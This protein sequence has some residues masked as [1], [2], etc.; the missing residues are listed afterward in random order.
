VRGT[1]TFAAFAVLCALCVESAFA[2]KA[3]NP[4]HREITA[5]WVIDHFGEKVPDAS[6]LVPYSVHFH[7]ILRSCKISAENLTNTMLFLAYKASDQ[8]QRFVTSLMM[9]KAVTRRITWTKPASCKRVFDVAEG[10]MEAGGP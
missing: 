9:M 1:A 8:G 5:M 4:H 2:K 6:Y 7:K 10:Y 3:P